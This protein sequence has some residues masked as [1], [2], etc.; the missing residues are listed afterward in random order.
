MYAYCIDSGAAD[1]FDMPNTS[2]E[3]H[4]MMKSGLGQQKG[5]LAGLRSLKSRRSSKNAYMLLLGTSGSGK[6]S[7]VSRRLDVGYIY[8]CNMKVISKLQRNFKQFFYFFC[9]S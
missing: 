4:A 6:S 5:L 9:N 8:V 3:I 2:D 1:L 7:T